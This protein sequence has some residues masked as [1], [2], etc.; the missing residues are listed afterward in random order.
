VHNRPTVRQRHLYD[1]F[2][3]GEL[4]AVRLAMAHGWHSHCIGDRSLFEMALHTK[5]MGV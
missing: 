2:T 4:S 5:R 3:I 1:S